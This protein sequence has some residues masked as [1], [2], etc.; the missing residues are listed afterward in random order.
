M[1]LEIN[2]FRAVITL[3]NVI[4]IVAFGLSFCWLGLAV[5]LFGIMKDLTVDKKINGF[6]MHGANAILNIYLLTLI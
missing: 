5:A 2:D 4:L 3:I 1:K 6:V